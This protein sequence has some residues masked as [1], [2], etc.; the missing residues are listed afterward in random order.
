MGTIFSSKIYYI[1]TKREHIGK[2]Y[3]LLML[4]SGAEFTTFFRS[5]PAN[6]I[7]NWGWIFVNTWRW[8][9]GATFVHI[10]THLI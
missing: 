4:R 7:F 2:I 8:I 6:N 9:F 10:K 1:K 3:R 5:N